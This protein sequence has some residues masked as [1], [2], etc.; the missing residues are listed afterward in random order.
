MT[1]IENTNAI[2]M[3]QPNLSFAVQFMDITGFAG[4][5][6]VL[7]YA[8]QYVK[9]DSLTAVFYAYAGVIITTLFSNLAAMYVAVKTVSAGMD[10]TVGLFY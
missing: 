1:T 2:E 8:S 9:P 3:M 6:W 5:F 10:W 4:T 7:Q